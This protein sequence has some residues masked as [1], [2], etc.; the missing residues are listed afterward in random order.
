MT[1]Q[2]EKY[3]K[4]TEQDKKD[5]FIQKLDKNHKKLIG[6]VTNKKKALNK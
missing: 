6:K 2:A 3:G 5:E 4:L 1:D